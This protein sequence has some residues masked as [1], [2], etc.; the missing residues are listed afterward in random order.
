MTARMLVVAAYVAVAGHAVAQDNVAMYGVV[1]MG[2]SHTRNGTGTVTSLNSGLLNGSRLGFK[3]TEALGNGV[4]AFFTLENGFAADTGA[5]GQGGLLFGRQAFVGLAGPYGMLKLGRQSTPVYANNDVF[6]PFGNGLAPDS[7]RLIN[8]SGSRT[9]NLLSYGLEAGGWRAQLQYA[10]GE[11]AGNSAA[12]RTLAGY[13][14]YRGGK[15]DTV[16]TYQ[17]TANAAGDARGSTALVGGNVNFGGIRL[18][19]AYAWNRNVTAPGGLIAPGTDMRNQLLGASIPAAGAGSIRV[20]YVT[21]RDR[22][23]AQAD[24]H[25]FGL[26]YIHD[27]SKRTALY[28]SAAWM[29]HE[30]KGNE[31]LANMGI[32]H[33]F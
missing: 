33:R 7:V 29:S 28:T 24:A 10:P 15:L 23:S 17:S 1:D 13:G 16:A 4:T 14:G 20:S 31:R 5:M 19:A 30:R 9:N 8:Y 3:G 21:L 27:L 18:Y 26:G 2:W 25:Q 22:R 6:D 11:A 12:G 32:R